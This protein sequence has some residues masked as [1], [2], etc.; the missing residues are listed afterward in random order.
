MSPRI[1]CP[2]RKELENELNERG[3]LKRQAEKLFGTRKDAEKEKDL[4]TLQGK[5]NDV[6]ARIKKHEDEIG[7]SKCGC[8]Q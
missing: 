1:M 5:Y 4:N 8:V 7:I 2:K 6:L 3:G